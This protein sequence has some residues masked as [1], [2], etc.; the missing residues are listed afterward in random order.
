MYIV[1]TKDLKKALQAIGAVSKGKKSLKVLEYVTLEGRPGGYL[2]ITGT[3]LETSA[4]IDIP[5]AISGNT[6]AVA[7]HYKTLADGL[8]GMKDNQ[9]SIKI[10]ESGQVMLSGTESGAVTL[11]VFDIAEYPVTPEVKKWA[12]FS[13]SAREFLTGLE[14]IFFTID[15]DEPRPHFRGGLLHLKD[16]Y[17]NMVGTDT[18]QLIIKKVQYQSETGRGLVL[19]ITADDPEKLK[20]IEPENV[21]K[22]I[23]PHKSIKNLLS[24]LKGESGTLEVIAD[25]RYIRIFSKDIVI[26]CMLFSNPEDFPKY[27]SVIP[28]GDKIITCNPDGSKTEKDVQKITISKNIFPL[29][30]GFDK[31]FSVSFAFNCTE[32]EINGYA[33]KAGE[34]SRQLVY[35]HKIPVAISG[36]SNEKVYHQGSR[37]ADF[38]RTSEKLYN[39]ESVIWENRG[40][41]LPAVMTFGDVVY[42]TMPLKPEE[43]R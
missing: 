39:P 27:E 35:T 38:F 13:V 25:N 3:D 4:K 40:G 43:S 18:K 8:K 6:A 16:E 20:D 24:I 10:D 36:E 22:V 2:S 17:I 34:Y 11:S 29:L 26:T 15:K 28:S 42:L 9:V 33:N 31:Y 41:K 19:C 7:V 1:N 14:T 5:A 37:L 32:A 30:S 21:R 12:S 23:I